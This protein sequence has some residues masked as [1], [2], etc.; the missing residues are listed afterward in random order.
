MNIICKQ[1]KKEKSPH[2]I[3]KKDGTPYTLKICYDCYKYQQNAYSINNKI[4]YAQTKKEYALTRYWK[5]RGIEETKTH[6]ENL[7]DKIESYQKIIDLLEDMIEEM[8]Q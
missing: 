8:E 7:N 6:I 1:C 2:V 4:K 3:F 5:N